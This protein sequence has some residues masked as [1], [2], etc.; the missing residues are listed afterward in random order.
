MG[1][2]DIELRKVL[3]SNFESGIAFPRVPSQGRSSGRSIDFDRFHWL[4]LG[5]ETFG[6]RGNN[7]RM[8]LVETTNLHV[9][10]GDLIKVAFMGE[11]FKELVKSLFCCVDDIFLSQK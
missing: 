11:D 10:H 8:D 7:F 2:H 5:G 3:L 4:K 6:I 1:R 9:F